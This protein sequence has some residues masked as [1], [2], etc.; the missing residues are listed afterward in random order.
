MSCLAFLG[1]TERAGKL[2]TGEES[3]GM[4][5]RAGK[6]RVLLLASDA[7]RST[8]VRGENYAEAGHCLPVSL[9]YT[10]DELGT[11]LG[12]G[13]VSMAAVTDIGMASAFLDKLSAERPGEYEAA[14]AELQRALA[15]AMERR[16]EARRH[17]EN[18]RRGKSKK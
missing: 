1:L 10:R 8:R 18:V 6:A 16:K 11:A 15:R 7:G 5:A 17:K 4:A 13:A 14:A 9:P 12:R 3:C 2:V